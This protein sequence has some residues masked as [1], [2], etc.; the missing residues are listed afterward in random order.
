MTADLRAQ[1][2]HDLETGSDGAADPIGVPV[3]DIYPDKIQ[4]PCAVVG[5]EPGQYVVAGQTFPAY[6]FRYVVV[7]LVQRSPTALTELETLVTRTLSNTADWG[8]RGVDTPSVF[9]ENGMEL[10]GTTVHLG[11][12]SKL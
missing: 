8:M 9:T 5:F 3:R 12:Q 2:I 7:L 11:K 6:E 4:P 1:L 10:L